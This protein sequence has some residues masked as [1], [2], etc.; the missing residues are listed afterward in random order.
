VVPGV[1]EGDSDTPAVIHGSP[2]VTT[3]VNV[4]IRRA[5]A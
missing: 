5:D 3:D 4:G 1:V 2:A